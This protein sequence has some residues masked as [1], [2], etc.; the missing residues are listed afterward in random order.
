MSGEDVY[1]S[2]YIFCSEKD[3]NNEGTRVIIE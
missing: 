2:M 1:P 3:E